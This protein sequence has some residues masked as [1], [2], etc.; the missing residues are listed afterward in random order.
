MSTV[1]LDEMT[2]VLKDAGYNIP[3][4]IEKGHRDTIETA[5]LVHMDKI[6]HDD[7]MKKIKDNKY[8]QK[9]VKKETEIESEESTDNE[10]SEDEKN[11]KVVKKK[12]DVNSP[13]I[14]ILLKILNHILKGAEKAEITSIYD[15]QKIDRNEIIKK[16]NEEFLEKNEKEIYTHFDK[17]KCGFY[18]KDTT[19][20]YILTF[21]RCATSFCDAKFTYK[22]THLKIG[23]KNNVLVTLYSVT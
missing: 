22:R 20:N 1:S 4:L 13:K 23:D 21:L 15:F 17:L 14:K 16:Q 8:N 2:K 9:D 6:K 12:E 19:A 11:A 10:S 5:Y 18:R 7:A 3:S